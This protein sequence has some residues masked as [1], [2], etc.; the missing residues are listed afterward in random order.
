VAQEAHYYCNEDIDI[1][2]KSNYQLD[3]VDIHYPMNVYPCVYN[4]QLCNYVLLVTYFV[5]IGV[6]VLLVHTH[7]MKFNHVS[8]VRE[9]CV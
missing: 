1:G 4:Y 3:S 7:V 2:K 8:G 6:G 9:L 5:V